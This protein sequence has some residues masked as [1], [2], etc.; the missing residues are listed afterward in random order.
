MRPGPGPARLRA[1]RRARRPRGVRPSR[2]GLGLEF[3]GPTLGQPGGLGRLERAEVGLAAV[4]VDRGIGE[5]TGRVG[6]RETIDAGLRRVVESGVGRASAPHHRGPG[7]AA[8]GRFQRQGV[9]AGRAGAGRGGNIRGSP[10]RTIGA[11]PPLPARWKTHSWVKGT[12]S[13]LAG[14][15]PA[16]AS[17]GV[18][19]TR[20]R[21]RPQ[22]RSTSQGSPVSSRAE[23]EAPGTGA[24][25]R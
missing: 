14:K 12:K 6:E 21:P 2:S 18:A 7:R 4:A 16:S 5:G 24:S 19:S 11:G 3:Q 22:G 10:A 23:T 20:T 15:V 25:T 9:D 13:G 17:I 8:V 1:C